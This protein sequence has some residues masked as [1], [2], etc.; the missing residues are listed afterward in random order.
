MDEGGRF[1][2]MG[3]NNLMG[4]NISNAEVTSDPAKIFTASFSNGREIWPD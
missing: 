2:P 4:V 1:I 3:L